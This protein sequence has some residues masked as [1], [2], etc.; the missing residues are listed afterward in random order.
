MRRT[1]AEVMAAIA[2]WA[3]RD[4]TGQSSKA[5]AREAAGMFA[6]S[7]PSYPHD[8]A[9]FARCYRLIK[10]VP[11][12]RRAVD[13]LGT[14]SPQWAKLAD[15]WD[16]LSATYAEERDGQLRSSIFDVRCPRAY[17]L[18]KWAIP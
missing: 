11:E 9:D 1:D 4:D 10:T 5:L 13:R 17:A 7:A 12:V 15:I 16:D 14:L 3:L 2:A 6:A 8:I 18:L